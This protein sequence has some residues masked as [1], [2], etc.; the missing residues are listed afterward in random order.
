MQ[1]N[2]LLAF[3][4]CG[5]AILLL[6]LT[7][8]WARPTARVCA[9]LAALI[10]LLTLVEYATGWNLGMDE[11]LYLDAD[12]PASPHPGRME[13]N[14]A[15]CFFL[16]GIAFWLMCRVAGDARRAL[17]LGVLGVLIVTIGIITLVGSFY[18]L[19]SGHGGWALAT[20]VFHESVL[21]ILL[22]VVVLHFAWKEKGERWVIGGWAT[23]GFICTLLL[24][25]ATAVFSQM[26]SKDLVAAAARVSR[27]GDIICRITD[28]RASSEEASGGVRGYVITGDETFFQG[29]TDAILELGKHQRQLRELNLDD[30]SQWSQLAALDNM[31]RDRLEIFQQVVALRRTRGFEAAAEE[32]ASGRGRAVDNE[33]RK[34]LGEMA[35][36][37]EQRLA[38]RQKQADATTE[39]TF[40]IL[41]AGLLLSLTLL[42]LGVL[43]LQSEVDAR[44]RAGDAL[45]QS[46]KRLRLALD[47]A[48]IGDWEL[49]LVTH[50]SRRSPKHDQIFGYEHL[51]PEWSYEIFLQHVY[52]EDRAR[53]DKAFQDSV[54]TGRDLS[55]ECRINK[56]DGTLGWI[57]ARGSLER[58]DSGQL[59]RMHGM[60]GDDTERQRALE[61][62]R[63]SE[64]RLRLAIE[65]AN[66][67]VWEWDLQTDAITW[68]VSMFK[69]YGLAEVPGGRVSYQVWRDRVLPEDFAEQEARLKQTVATGGSDQRVF[70]IMRASDHAVR[71]I[72]AAELVVKGSESKA[73]RVVGINLD[74]T[75]RKEAEDKINQLNDDLQ[76]R[77]AELEVAVKELEAFSYSVAHDLRAPLRAVDGFSRMLIEDYAEHLGDD[78]HRKLTVIRSETQRMGRLI[79]D[80]LSFSRISRQQVEPTQIDMQALA[81]TIFNEQAALD[82]VRKLHLTLHPLPSAYGTLAMIRQV[83]VNLISN[84]IKFTREREVGEIEIGVLEDAEEG[85]AYYI[86]DNGAGFDM[87][88][89][90]K[91]FGVFQRLHDDQAFEGTGVGLALVQRIVQRH[92]GRVWAE[93][94][95]N[96]GATF[97]FTIRNQNL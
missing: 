20:L 70:R 2:A 68:D 58:D 35:A 73:G 39:R 16:T 29:Y 94:E 88:H 3:L 63:E 66:F 89:A 11:L 85:P 10:G 76:H 30:A 34:L 36:V 9:V 41:P 1:A 14:A 26:R 13:L 91:L 31:I 38:I 97:Y 46:E 50:A 53:V 87:R 60:V 72:Q 62:L 45:L 74:I 71:W 17:V 43:R 23:I 59:V 48:Q 47:A 56:P 28:L 22:G 24:L 33:F 84:A 52:P 67:A 15:L 12:A 40:I 19:S 79:D 18:E 21:F 37:Q 57:W 81:Q 61:S 42:T 65:A 6:P 78:G 75:E 55:F 44:Q 82:P 25:V 49:D 64:E 96:H 92:H 95:V 5:A 8:S 54:A 69:I 86:K 90:G 80:L 7:R 32:I 93:A 51:L 83:W 77:A 27:T 4:F